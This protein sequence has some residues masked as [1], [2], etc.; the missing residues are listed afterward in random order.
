MYS[1]VLKKENTSGFESKQ[2]KHNLNAKKKDRGQ[3][4]LQVILRN[5]KHSDLIMITSLYRKLPICHA[6][7]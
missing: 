5:R 7:F 1:D 3:K 4:N 2:G 6:Q